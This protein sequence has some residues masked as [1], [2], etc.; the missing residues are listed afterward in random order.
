MTTLTLTDDERRVLEI[1]G[2]S[3]RGLTVHGA[4]Q[5]GPESEVRGTITRLV[6][7][8]YLKREGTSKLR[9]YVVTSLGR[10]YLSVGEA[11]R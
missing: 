4:A 3:E 8:G 7:K 6:R 5:G 2:K 11:G 9:W 10:G 1:V